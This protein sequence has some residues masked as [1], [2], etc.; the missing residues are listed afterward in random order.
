MEEY[1]GCREEAERETRCRRAV[2]SPKRGRENYAPPGHS[3]SMVKAALIVLAAAPLFAQQTA[4]FSTRIQLTVGGDTRVNDSIRSCV[5]D[6]LRE[7]P[8]VVVSEERRANYQ[9]DIV[10]LILTSTAGRDTGLAVSIV[11]YGV[12]SIVQNGAILSPI[13]ARSPIAHL[14][15]TGDDLSEVCTRAVAHI[16][17]YAIEPAREAWQARATPPSTRAPDVFDKLKVSTSN[18]GSITVQIE[19][20]DDAQ[21]IQPAKR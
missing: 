14:L 15:L 6:Q 10:P 16:Q 9:V 11:I 4:Q 8:G 3:S 2:G 1:D 20:L 5:A 12:P 17:Q 18:A 19:D 13:D 21:G 7:L